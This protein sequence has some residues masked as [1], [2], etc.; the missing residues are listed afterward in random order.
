[1]AE[2]KSEKTIEMRL[3]EIEDKLAQ[4]HISEEDM[5][6]YQKVATALGMGGAGGGQAAAAQQIP[7]SR[8][9]TS[10][11]RICIIRY[12]CICPCGPCYECTCGPCNCAG[13]G[14]AFG[15][16]FGGFGG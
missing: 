5:K 1:M 8:G 11:C 7:I 6:T 3:A 16:G 14:G 4:M 2:P 9:I 13:G 12:T 15:G 10:V